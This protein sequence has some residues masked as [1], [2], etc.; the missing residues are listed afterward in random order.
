MRYVIKVA[1]DGTAYGGWQIQNNSVT[2]QEK[3]TQALNNVIGGGVTVKASGR[4]D[5][6]VHAAGQI[7]HFDAM[8][9]IPPEKIADALNTVLPQDISVLASAAAPDGFDAQS[10]AKRK[11]YLYRLYSSRYPNP[12]KERYAVRIN[13][14]L[15]YG[16]LAQAAAF[17]EGEH[18]FKAY[19]SSGSSVKTTVRR[20]Y[21]VNVDVRA[22]GNE[23][24]VE[25]R[26]TGNGFL[27]NMVRTLVGTMLFYASDII[28]EGR[29]LRSLRAGDRDAVGKTMPAKGLVLESVDYGTVLF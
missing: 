14:G 18:D 25:I 23:T 27:Y 20:I 9:T 2:V 3:L 28:D 29:I 4:T 7:C 11:T 10:S 16:K 19:C 22:D 15:D 13:N 8:T 26:V 1:Y 5:A 6:G 21:S 17:F 24:D 12:L